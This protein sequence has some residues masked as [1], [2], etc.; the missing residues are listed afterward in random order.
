MPPNEF[1]DWFWMAVVVSALLLFVGHWFPWPKELHKLGAY[2]YGVGSILAGFMLWQLQNG[3][4][5]PVL[6]LLVIVVVS[7]IAVFL[8]YGLDWLILRVRQSWKAEA[9]D[10]D[11]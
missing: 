2:V 5:Q 11:L 9:D 7:G 6:G 1:G 10:P 8:A 4:W 3:N